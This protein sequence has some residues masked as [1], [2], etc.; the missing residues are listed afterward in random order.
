MSRHLAFIELDYF[1]VRER[2]LFDG[3]PTVIHHARLVLDANT[4]AEERGVSRGMTLAEAKAILAGEGQFV[5]W[6]AD[7][8]TSARDKWLD[9]VA[10][11]SDIIEPVEQHQCFVD[12]S[13]HPES[14]AV[15]E[16]IRQRLE[17]ATGKGVRVGEGPCRWIARLRCCLPV[18]SITDLDVIHLPVEPDIAR[19]LQALGCRSIGEVT[20][21]PISLLRQQFG[22]LA[23]H[24]QLAAKGRGDDA[25]LPSYPPNSLSGRFTFDGAADTREIVDRG[26]R[27]LSESLGF[28]LVEKGLFSKQ[29]VV[30]IELESGDIQNQERTFGKP[31]SSPVSVLAALSVM[32]AQINRPILS[33]RVRLPDLQ[34]KRRVQRTLSG[35]TAIE[36]KGDS[37]HNALNQLRSKFGNHSILLADQVVVERFQ[38]VRQAWRA[39]N[40]WNWK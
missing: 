24:I 2:G 29:L 37:V 40:G 6:E 7:H 1:Y 16:Q 31:L 13:A 28:E 35:M 27:K 20:Q 32:L 8:Y 36:A 21:L 11:F 4:A 22:K 25:V 17:S 33:I 30:W 10:I 38:R 12:L 34:H 23:F 5:A 3:P 26:L 18:V 15:A 9:E 19:R 14:N 39:V